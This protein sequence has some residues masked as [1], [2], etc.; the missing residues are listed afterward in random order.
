MIVA[1]SHY[2]YRVDS[3]TNLRKITDGMFRP[4]KWDG[5]ADFVVPHKPFTQGIKDIQKG[6]CF[7]RICFWTTEQLASNDHAF[8]DHHASHLKM[9]VPIKHVIDNLPGYF[10]DEDDLI[11]GEYARMFW[12]LDVERDIDLAC[13][14]IPIEYFEIENP[15][16]TWV[17]MMTLDV[18]QPEHVRMKDI[19]MQSIGYIDTWGQE[20][21]IYWKLIE[22]TYFGVE[23]WVV[24]SQENSGSSYI[25]NN[26][27]LLIALVDQILIVSG[28]NKDGRG[29]GILIV[30][31]E[32]RDTYFV[33]TVA[34]SYRCLVAGS[35]LNKLAVA[36]GLKEQK[37]GYKAVIGTMRYH[38][39]EQ[40]Q[41]LIQESGLI[42]QCM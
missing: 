14:G 38:Q 22:A 40:I 18:L 25:I 42:I 24:I 8:R 2:L 37:Y 16:G 9:R 34:K 6:E 19:D 28:L 39:Y 35:G 13:N 12:K 41:P 7:Y 4:V 23:K 1:D 17:P 15:D 33:S 27:A 20:S 30:A 11:G 32:G 26:E 36:I 3:I 10:N 29:V 5:C 21:K 31:G